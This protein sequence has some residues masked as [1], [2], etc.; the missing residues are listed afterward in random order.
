MDDSQLLFCIRS[1][2]FL[3]WK[4]KHLYSDPRNSSLPS[5][6]QV[7]CLLTRLVPSRGCSVYQVLIAGYSLLVALY[8]F[9]NW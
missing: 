8:Y 2:R 6:Y 7:I 1:I 4:V 9:M 3:I 5:L